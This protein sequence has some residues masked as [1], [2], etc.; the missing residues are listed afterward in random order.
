MDVSLP[1]VSHGM[2]STGG[3]GGGFNGG[4]SQNQRMP[5]PPSGRGKHGG[6]RGGAVQE[7]QSLS[8][9]RNQSADGAPAPGEADLLFANHLRTMQPEVLARELKSIMDEVTLVKMEKKRE[10]ERLQGR[11]REAGERIREADR[12]RAQDRAYREETNRKHET[13]AD[14]LERGHQEIKQLERDKRKLHKT[15]AELN[16]MHEEEKDLLMKEKEAFESKISEALDVSLVDSKEARERA[17]DLAAR[18]ESSEADKERLLESAKTA[19]IGL[20]R[21]LKHARTSVEQ[22]EGERQAELARVG[23]LGEKVMMLESHLLQFLQANETLSKRAG[24][25]EATVSTLASTLERERSSYKELLDECTVHRNLEEQRRLEAK[26]FFELQEKAAR[27]DLLEPDLDHTTGQLEESRQL[28]DSLR[29]ELQITRTDLSRLQELQGGIV[30]AAERDRAEC[31]AKRIEFTEKIREAHERYIELE[32]ML[33]MAVQANEDVTRSHDIAMAK[34]AEHIDTLN[35]ENGI[36]SRKITELEKYERQLVTDT[37][38]REIQLNKTQQKKEAEILE[39]STRRQRE[40]REMARAREQEWLIRSRKTEE[41]LVERAKAREE[42]LIDQ[43]RTKIQQVMRDAAERERMLKQ[44]TRDEMLAMVLDFNKQSKKREVEI[45][46]R[47]KDKE[48]ALDENFRL[49]EVSLKKDFEDQEKRNHKGFRSEIDAVQ[50]QSSAIQ[51]DLRQE[52]R[53]L[54]EQLKHAKADGRGGGG[55]GFGS[56]GAGAQ[57]GGAVTEGEMRNMESEEMAAEVQSLTSQLVEAKKDIQE[58]LEQGKQYKD[59]LGREMNLL[60]KTLQDDNP[61]KELVKAWKLENRWCRLLEKQLA[62]ANRDNGI[63]GSELQYLESRIAETQ[64]S[65]EEALNKVTASREVFE[66]ELLGLEKLMKR[67]ARDRKK[68]MA[69]K[70]LETLED[71]ESSDDEGDDMD[72]S[73]YNGSQVSSYSGESE[74]DYGS[75]SGNDSGSDSRSGSSRSGSRSGSS[76]GSRS[77]SEGGRSD[78]RSSMGSRGSRPSS[79]GSDR[80]DRSGASGKGGQRMASSTGMK[81]PFKSFRGKKRE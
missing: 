77:P 71:G 24:D 63:L 48:A 33:R 10:V 19:K 66:S 58:A 50:T 35:Q 36:L 25:A 5:Q 78:S 4:S 32:E 16:K 81:G 12:I 7:S 17:E 1:R 44:E 15:I 38:L 56:P 29:R 55:G 75:D 47:Q 30:A 74:S 60:H 8:Q 70:A 72:G 43:A 73:Q 57:G 49:G 3:G 67:K 41:E 26:A 54:K 27:V 80:T 13:M 62:R 42:E 18:L 61:H 14:A 53:I 45:S 9:L 79:A 52:I 39:D 64:R 28:A 21:E 46:D 2:G 22:T 6:G 65:K 37:K 40:L 51:Y 31:E 59:M 34:A 23:D 76:M 20:L 68:E 11:L 69:A